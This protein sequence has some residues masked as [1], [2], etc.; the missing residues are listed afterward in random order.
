MLPRPRLGTVL[1]S[2]LDR[3]YDVL[4]P[5]NRRRSVLAAFFHFVA[6]ALG[7]IQ[8]LHSGVN[9]GLGFHGFYWF[10]RTGRLIARYPFAVAAAC[11][12]L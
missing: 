2:E 5:V 4:K 8:F 9:I 1:R 11:S 7:L 3:T 10:D 12:P 6:L